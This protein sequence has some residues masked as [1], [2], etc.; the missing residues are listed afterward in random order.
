MRLR[1]F[2]LVIAVL[3]ATVVV[4]PAGPAFSVSEAQVDAA[5]AD[6]ETAYHQYKEQNG[7]FEAATERYEQT[8]SELQAT[9]LEA[10]YVRTRVEEKSSE[11]IDI[12]GRVQ[13]RAIEMYITASTSLTDMLF[14]STSVGEFIAGRQ[15]IETATE[16]DVASLDLLQ[17]LRNDL[18][19]LREDLKV[20][21]GKLRVLQ[22][23]QE[24]V[25]DVLEVAVGQAHASW[26][27]LST[28]CKELYN[29]RQ[30]ELA[31]AEAARLARLTGGGG[32]VGKA[33]T[34]NFQCPM[35]PGP[36]HFSNTWG[37]PRSGGRTHKGTDLFAPYGQK[38]YAAADG[39]V[40]LTSGGLG[41][42]SVWLSADHGV[43][44]YYT[45]LS[46][47]APGLGSGDIVNRGQ[48]IGYNGNSG[49]ARGGSP[50][51]HFQ[52]HPGGR[53]RPPVNPYQ[54]LLNFGCR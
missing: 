36:S 52:V 43:A 17:A 49:N 19:L 6:S 10:N 21:E 5:C 35:D 48:V 51:V 47:W 45:H 7:R 15:F 38:V 26:Q 23:E 16:R 14:A 34:P 9:V 11:V 44:Y 20:E 2:L 3:L 18:G 53:G 31:A 42:V 8:T 27:K 41:G 4:L 40:F 32:G 1:A 22:G 54:T 46:G 33:L 39:V 13:E 25:K 37:A 24:Q 30:A 28:R 29:K 50:H 12:R